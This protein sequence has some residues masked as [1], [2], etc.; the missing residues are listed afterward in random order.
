MK[1]Y[2][3]KLELLAIRSICKSDK[4]L[5]M[6]LLASVT[7]DYFHSDAAKEAIE[8]ILTLV[9]KE[10]DIPDY[11]SITSDPVI[12][13][14][15]RDILKKQREYVSSEKEV[16]KTIKSLFKYKQA[17]DL[18]FL[19]EKINE[20][21]TQDKVDVSKLIEYTTTKVSKLKVKLETKEEFFH[22]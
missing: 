2:D 12:S 18:Y 9:K 20:T 8:R 19:S 1:L 21:L 15:S 11:N 22:F 7:S 13:E 3:S 5:K 16:S 4:K 6:K 17:R 10:S 14:A